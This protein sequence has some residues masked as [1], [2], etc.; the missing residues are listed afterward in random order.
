MDAESNA[1]SPKLTD[2]GSL[3]LVHGGHGEAC[4]SS[5]GAW[6]EAWERY[7]LAARVP[8]LLET[9]ESRPLRLLDV[10]TGLGWNIAALLRAR[11][12]HAPA[13]PLEVTT[14][15]IDRRVIEVACD[16]YE[17]EL[18][19]EHEKALREVH[20]S[21]GLALETPDAGAVPLGERGDSL[22]LLI[23]DARRTLPALRRDA[24]FDVVF[25]DPFSPA[26][27]GDLWEPGFLAEIAGRMAPGSWLST[28][29]AATAVRVGLAV[30]GLNVGAGP[31]VGR[32]AEGTIA[33]PDQTPP[34]FEPRIARRI[35]RRVAEFELSK[36]PFTP[37]EGAKS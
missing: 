25:L 37:P 12:S 36:T 5:A 30:V 21:L 8:A 27:D 9:R 23:G 7:V 1:W 35:S 10:G 19:E 20:R 4:H 31:R 34:P 17:R 11:S 32:K 29:S 15:E 33:S 14:L 6:T 24:R 22:R 18:L 16:L 2:D 13:V 3:T 28:Y 26:V